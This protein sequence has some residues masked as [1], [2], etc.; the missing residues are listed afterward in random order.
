[1][2]TEAE[3]AGL[4]RRDPSDRRRDEER[5]GR[6]LLCARRPARCA[7]AISPGDAGAA[8]PIVWANLPQR[9]GRGEADHRRMSALKAKAAMW[10]RVRSGGRGSR[11]GRAPP[12]YDAARR[13]GVRSSEGGGGHDRVHV[14]HC[15][16]A[17]PVRWG[18]L[19][20]LAVARVARGPAARAPRAPSAA[21]E[22]RT[23]SGATGSGTAV[24]GRARRRGAPGSK[25]TT[26]RAQVQVR[27][28]RGRRTIDHAPHGRGAGGI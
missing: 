20:L 11:P 1:L 8:S 5:L 15:A 10:R 19:G 7:S 25:S 17:F 6:R 22:P 3:A 12:A 4:A 26:A 28:D 14:D 13:R 18:G 24:G 27:A 2:P 21:P 23:P 9:S 16:R